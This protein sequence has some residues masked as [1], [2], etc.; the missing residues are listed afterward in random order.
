MSS[1][2]PIGMQMLAR[3]LAIAAL[4]F[5]VALIA[6]SE[7]DLLIW[8]AAPIVIAGLAYVPVRQRRLRTLKMAAGA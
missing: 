8:S 3:V 2:A 4:L 6:A 1:A 5:C 7:P